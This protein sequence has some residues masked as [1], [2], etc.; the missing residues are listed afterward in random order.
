MSQEAFALIEII[1]VFF[2]VILIALLIKTIFLQKQMQFINWFAICSI[3]V[4]SAFVSAIL[5][6]FLGYAA[7]EIPQ[8]TDSTNYSYKFLAIVGLAIVNPIVAIWKRK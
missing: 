2:I 3:S 6:F 4:I 8:F 1:F 7:D 5:L